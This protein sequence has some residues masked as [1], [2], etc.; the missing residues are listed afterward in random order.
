MHGMIACGMRNCL[1]VLLLGACGLVSG[2]EGTTARTGA[3]ADQASYVPEGYRLVW[4]DEFDGTTLN[5]RK[6][7]LRP[8]MKGD[9][10]LALAGTERPEVVRVA[11]GKLQLNAVMDRPPESGNP[12]YTTCFS[13][14]TYNKMHFRYGYLEMRARV[15]YKRSAWPSLWMKSLPGD[16]APAGRADY[17]AEVD[18]FEV[19]SSPD[20]AAPNLHKW[21][22]N[23]KHSSTSSPTRHKFTDI[24]DLNNEYHIYGFEWTPRSMSMYLDGERYGYYDLSVDFGHKDGMAGFHETLYVIINNHVFTNTSPWKPQDS[25]VNSS[26]CLPNHYWIDWIRLYQ[27]PGE[28]A[29]FTAK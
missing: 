20:T 3:E 19:F 17:M 4:S 22:R 15:P 23:G 14:T 25:E 13:V 8:D 26:S 10:E 2:A 16:I 1:A 11:D 5:E 9:G 28:G 27:K 18:V 29:L 24:A 21:H 12:L 7:T 6:W